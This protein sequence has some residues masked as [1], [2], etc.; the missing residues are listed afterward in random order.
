MVTFV[1]KPL[2][3]GGLCPGSPGHLLHGTWSLTFTR[4]FVLDPTAGDEPSDAMHPEPKTEVGAYS[5]T[6]THTHTHTHLL[7][8]S[9]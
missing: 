2:A 8:A 7:K 1:Q 4:G 3:S 5:H 6:H 9:R